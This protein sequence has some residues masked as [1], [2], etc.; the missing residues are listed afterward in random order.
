MA[1][2][3]C[4]ESNLPIIWES[5]ATITQMVSKWFGERFQLPI[6]FAS[7]QRLA[8]GMET[9]WT[10]SSVSAVT[11][12]IALLLA[13][14]ARIPTFQRVAKIVGLT[15]VFLIGASFTYNLGYMAGSVDQLVSD[16][17][18][19][20]AQ[21]GRIIV[22]TT[23]SMTPPMLQT[24]KLISLAPVNQQPIPTA[25]ETDLGGLAI[26][27]GILRVLDRRRRRLFDSK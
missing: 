1:S 22:G 24:A 17:L 18:N 15:A 7:G 5:Y 11:L 2:G 6:N 21:N 10:V 8:F 12:L 4:R 25:V 20:R 9:V 23:D 13:Y 14:L 26:A 3:R 27:A 16:S 19:V